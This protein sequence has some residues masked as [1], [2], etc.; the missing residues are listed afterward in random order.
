MPF[1]VS[2]GVNVS[3]ID[4]TTS[5]PAIATSIGAL[6]GKFSW[7][8]VGEIVNVS[9]E[10]ELV[11]YF[12]RPT[13]DNYKSWYTA[14]NFLSYAN[15]LRISRVIGAGALNAV[16]GVASTNQP[17]DATETFAGV[18]S[19]TD[20]LTGVGAVT[21]NETGD[22]TTTDFTIADPGNRTVTVSVDGV[23][24]TPDVDFSI[25]GTTLSFA[26]GTSPFGAP[27]NADAIVITT[28]AQTVFTL[29]R[30][31][32]GAT[33]TVTVNGVAET[34]FS[35]TV[36]QLTF[37]TAPAD[38]AA[39][40][41]VIPARVNFTV[42][43]NIDATDTLTVVV[44]GTE[45]TVTTDYSVNGQVV[46]F[47][48]A[49]ADG[50]SVVITVLGAASTSFS[51]TPILVKSADDI[52]LDSGQANDAVFAARCAGVDGNSLKTYLADAATFAD[53]PTNLKAL[54]N[55]PPTAGE[56]HVI[57]TRRNVD[58]SET[59]LE[60]YEYLSKAS[61]GRAED[62]KNMYYVD[63]INNN[64]EYV[65]VL[66]HPT[67]GTDWGQ[68][69]NLTKP[70][71]SFVSLTSALQSEFGGGTAG[72]QPTAAEVITAYDIFKDPETV[73]ISL[74]MG[75]EWADLTNGNTVIQHI[76]QNVCEERK[77]CVALISPRYVDVKSGDPQNLISFFD[78]TVGAYSNYAFVDSN[79]KYQYDK[80]NDT[81]RWV[82]FNGD[83]A[84]LMARTDA[85]RDAW[86]SPAG[87][88]RGVIK[89]VV[90]VAWNQNKLDR[91]DLYKAAL[92]PIVTFPGQGTI[93]YGDKTFTN[94]PSAFDRI[95]VRRLFI[96]LE[97]SIATA[98][99]FTL[100][101]FNDEFTRTQFLSLVEPFLR[102][103]KG[104]R[105]IYDFLVVCDET[106]NTPEI[107]DRNEFVGDI[108][109][110]PARSINFIQLNFVAVRTGVSFE[111]VV[112]TI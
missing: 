41:V 1:Q 75:G 94:K 62:G 89:N 66:N 70:L 108:Y 10:T 39:I 101:E 35:V 12:G 17:V 30:D 83:V 77:D 68:E 8:P 25:S 69:T 112:G 72:S 59:T 32:F 61:N 111:E 4:L 92:N 51:Y 29:S 31:V 63:V 28:A 109:I 64:S 98:S 42:V 88:N 27:A 53:L 86:F 2:P 18:A 50:A 82:P 14:A 11:R 58:G 52:D 37:T 26:G 96:V 99:K 78:T 23:T 90:K 93:L 57:V 22:G 71:S 38:G 67:E 84:G 60:R 100:F 76:I 79:Y 104:R 110:K 65:W 102:D 13:A 21:Q 91:D 85:E 3:E 43:E 46:T 56:I 55:T 6:V 15:S 20:S 47:V 36:D 48:T 107:I 106:N 73:D 19:V 34:D 33:P 45:Q 87:F 7:G 40:S 24:L 16:A 97:K 49:P 9:T 81:Y 54:F 44:D 105:G 80:Y 95:N 103:V 5:T 74:V